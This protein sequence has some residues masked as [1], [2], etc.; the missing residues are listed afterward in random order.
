MDWRFYV[1]G[2]VGLLLGAI[3]IEGYLRRNQPKR[4]LAER[5]KP[6]YG[7]KEDVDGKEVVPLGM[8]A[9][10]MNVIRDSERLSNNIEHRNPSLK[11]QK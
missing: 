5:L 8:E 6:N 7:V 4:S 10:D 2:G 9:I 3:G 11:R 1:L